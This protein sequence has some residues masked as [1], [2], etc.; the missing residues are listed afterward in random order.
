MVDPG[1]L[2]SWGCCKKIPQTGWLQTREMYALT[3]LEAGSKIK[4][5]AGP[6]PLGEALPASSSFWEPQA[7]LGLWQHKLHPHVVSTLCVSSLLVR[8]AVMLD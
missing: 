1:E 2:A 6:K 5:L 8:T 4:M 7:F 3:V